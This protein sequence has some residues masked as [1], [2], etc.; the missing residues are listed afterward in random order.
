MTTLSSSSNSEV[1]YFSTDTKITE[2]QLFLT[3]YHWSHLP[4]VDVTG[5]WIG[6][7]YAEDL[8]ENDT[9]ITIEDVLYDLEYFYIDEEKHSFQYFDIFAQYDCNILPLLNPE[10]KIVKIIS[11]DSLCTEWST[12]EFVTAKGVSLLIE[13]EEEQYSFSEISQII[14]QNNVH[15][16]GVLVLNRWNNKTQLLVKTN[17]INTSTVLSDLRRYGYTILSKHAE[18]TYHTDLQENSDYLNKYLNI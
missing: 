9:A 15:L 18:D 10:G 8:L 7:I 1:P 12:I 2:A 13:K 3:R 6:N 5:K 14:E 17:G 16:F 11:R 4:I